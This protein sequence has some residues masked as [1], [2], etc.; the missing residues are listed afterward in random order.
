MKKSKFTKLEK[1]WILYD[2]GN[3]AFIMLVSTIIPI[4]F[5]S[6]AESA[7]ISEVDYL[8]Y[9]GYAV[10]LSTLIIAFIG[11]ILGTIS[12]TKGYRKPIFTLSMM[13]GV[14]CCAA[15]SLAT[16]WIIFLAIFVIAKVGYSASLIFYDSMLCDITTPERMDEVSSQGYA[17]GYIGSCIP[18]IIS[19]M[20]VLFYED[21]GISLAI[22]MMIAFFLNAGWWLL[23]TIPLLKNYEQKHYI[24]PKKYPIKESFQRF[25]NAIKEIKE[26]KKIFLFLLAFFFYID[27]VYTIIEMATAYGSA[28]GLDT[29]GLLLALLVTQLVAFPFAIL[30]GRLSRKYKTASLIKFCIIAYAGIALFAIQL[31]Q[32]WEFWFLAI[33]VGMFQG[34]VQALS[35]S[36]FAK[37]IPPEKTGEFFGIFD[38]CGK[39]ASFIGTALMGL[40]AQL[41]KN[42]NSGVIILVIMFIIGFFIF[43]KAE[44]TSD[45][46]K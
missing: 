30:F 12:D 23:V 21:I 14:I 44:R 41:T 46:T 40:F 13:I 29:Q 35:R 9:W 15:L 10:S 6:L 33:C 32:Q 20:F 27:G 2:V 7:N 11:P 18:F 1:Y 31:D 3:S 38:I 43:S 45:E 5:N 37:I 28:L 24:E 17:W 4:Y 16:S 34:A 36:Y 39:G 26:H 25:R 42:V 19:L 22:A 8:A